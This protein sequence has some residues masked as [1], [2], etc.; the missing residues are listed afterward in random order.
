[1]SRRE[2]RCHSIAMRIA[3]RS[4]DVFYLDASDGRGYS[5]CNRDS[6]E[7]WI[8]RQVR[9]GDTRDFWELIPF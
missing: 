5:F 8:A 1:M 3:W 9:R 4:P 7:C 2:D 6:A